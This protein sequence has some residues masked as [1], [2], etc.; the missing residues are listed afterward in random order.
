MIISNL[1]VRDIKPVLHTFSHLVPTQ[2]CPGCFQ[3]VSQ[4]LHDCLADITAGTKHS[5]G[6]TVLK[7][8]SLY[9]SCHVK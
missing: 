4:S 2:I 5:D 7:D 1:G 3:S 9:T 8:A 6:A